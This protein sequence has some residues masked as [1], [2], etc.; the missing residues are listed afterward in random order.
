MSP[1]PQVGVPLAA[2]WTCDIDDW[3]RALAWA[4]DGRALAVLGASG[5]LHLLDGARGEPIASV[6][7]HAAGGTAL[8]WS[9]RR[10]LLAT[11]GEDGMLRCWSSRLELRLE[12]DPSLAT[13][14]DGDDAPPRRRS[15]PW[16]E[17]MA[18]SRDGRRL[19]VAV[20]RHARVLDE[21]DTWAFTS[22]AQPST[23]AALCWHPRAPQ[24]T[25]VGYNG[26]RSYTLD[27]SATTGEAEWKGSFI[28]VAWSPDGRNLAAGMQ[29]GAVHIWQPG[30][31]DL[32]MSGYDVK[33]RALAWDSES[34]RLATG[35][36]ALVSV[37]KFSGAGPAGTRPQ[38]LEGH[39]LGVTALAFRHAGLLLASGGE[40]GVTCLHDLTR[41]D[42]TPIASAFGI[43]EV[44]DLAWDPTGSLVAAAHAS[45][46]ITALARPLR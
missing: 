30:K 29:E 13:R 16:V 11:G 46:L 18:W 42:T 14:D 7:A 37:W 12:V 31:P 43:G 2:R 17:S 23:I 40:D 36:G 19:A 8:A 3:P 24:V 32:Q 35:G 9:S 22:P 1:A 38:L 28:S 45:G 27:G 21:D 15:R 20:G 4:P 33:V 25:L 5:R 44:T 34:K 41:V 39:L 26:A 6:D 10:H